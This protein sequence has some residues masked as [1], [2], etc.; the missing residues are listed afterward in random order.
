MSKLIIVFG[1]K[2][3][4]GG[5][6]IEGFGQ[7]L[8]G[9]KLVVCIGDKVSC[10]CYGI[11]IIVSGDFIMVVDGVLV[12]CDGDKIVCGVVFIVGQVIMIF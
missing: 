5:S 4:Y 7:I 12:V 2:I 11:I 8:V 9:N 6:V 10:F 3:L 1:D